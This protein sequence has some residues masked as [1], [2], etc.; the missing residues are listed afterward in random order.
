VHIKKIF[1]DA[2]LIFIKPPSIDILKQRLMKRNRES[3]GE[4]KLRFER[5]EMEMEQSRLFDYQVVNDNLE[6]AVQELSA[7]IES[8][9]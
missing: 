8:Y 7:I 6:I 5:I 4:I 1:K 9:L 3:E 2:V